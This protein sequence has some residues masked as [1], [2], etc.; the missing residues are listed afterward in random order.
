MT[1]RGTA[2]A[3]WVNASHAASVRSSQAWVKCPL[4]KYLEN[5]LKV[6]NVDQY[7]GEVT[8]IVQP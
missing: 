2:Q 8:D 7:A 4:M 3:R 6:G 5:N 1:A